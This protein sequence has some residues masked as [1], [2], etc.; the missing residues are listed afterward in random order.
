MAATVPD[1]VSCICEKCSIDSNNSKTVQPK[2]KGHEKT[3]GKKCTQCPQI[4]ANDNQMKKH[5]KNHQSTL[6]YVCEICKLTFKTVNEARAHSVKSCGN[7]TQ[8]EVIIEIGEEEETKRCNACSTSYKSNKE[9]EKQKH[10]D[11]H[12]A[13]DCIKCHTKFTSQEDVYKHANT[14]SE[15]IAPFMCEKCNRELISKAGLE[16]HMTKCKGEERP[17]NVPKPKQQQSKE[18]D[19]V[20]PVDNKPSTD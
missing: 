11:S 2:E 15:I 9:L 7:I 8:K 16:K 20:G 13:V 18:L 10:M 17:V 12:H 1:G 14:C 3:N 5:M 19:G 6:N 4:A